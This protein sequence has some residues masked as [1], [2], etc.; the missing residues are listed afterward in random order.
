MEMND[1]FAKR[2]K[3]LLYVRNTLFYLS[4]LSYFCSL[5]ALVAAMVSLLRNLQKRH[6]AVDNGGFDECYR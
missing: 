5:D 4:C 1:T 2:K 6:L 3:R